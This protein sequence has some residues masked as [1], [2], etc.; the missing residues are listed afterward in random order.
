[1]RDKRSLLFLVEKK[2]V[3]LTFE[4]DSEGG[5]PALLP[6]WRRVFDLFLIWAVSARPDA[7][8]GE[9]CVQPRRDAL[10]TLSPPLNESF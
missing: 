1:M 2:S 8:Q 10:H 4:D 3:L 9:A 7:D 5:W 6:R